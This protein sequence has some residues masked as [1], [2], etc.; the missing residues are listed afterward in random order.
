MKKIGVSGSR[1]FNNEK[2]L[3][4]TL[5]EIEGIVEIVTGGAKGADQLAEKYA[6]EKGLKKKIFLPAWER[7][8]RFAGAIRNNDIIDYA[9]MMVILWDGKS[10]GTK[11]VIEKCKKR[12]KN[13]KLILF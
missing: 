6:D 10:K 9:D 13:Y 1:S 12:G 7:H 5:D 2:L 11:D 4:D 3:F 8:G